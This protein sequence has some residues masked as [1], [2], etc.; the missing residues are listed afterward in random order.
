MNTP[1]I[2]PAMDAISRANISSLVNSQKYWNMYRSRAP[3]TPAM[4]KT[5][6]TPEKSQRK[7]RFVNPSRR[8]RNTWMIGLRF[9]LAGGSDR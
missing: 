7:D 2:R 1:M 5:I 9:G 8:S 3:L 4:M 6:S